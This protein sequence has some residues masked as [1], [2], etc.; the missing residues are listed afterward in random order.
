MGK[1]KI[2]LKKKVLSNETQTHG[3]N[4]DKELDQLS[5]PAGKL[6]PFIDKMSIIV[7]IPPGEHAYDMYSEFITSSDDPD[8]FA[9]AKKISGFAMGKRIVIQAADEKDYPNFQFDHH[10]KQA[11]RFRLEFS[12]EALGAAGLIELKML[13]GGMMEGGWEFVLEHGKITKLEVTVDI[14]KIEIETLLVL[15]QQ[16]TTAQTWSMGGTL[17]TLVL[18]KA[19]SNQTRIYNRGAKRKAKG[20]HSPEYEGTRVERILKTNQPL[21]GL[22]QMANPLAGLKII[23]SPLPPPKEHK[24]YIWSLFMDAVHRRSLPVALGLLPPEKRAMYREWMT[25]NSVA[26]WQPDEIWAQWPS[27]LSDSKLLSS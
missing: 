17:Q 3:E 21:S 6:R 22:H 12:P 9:S 23:V 16:R 15:P 13:L 10:A 2:P 18:G 7:P 14:P 11:K 4:L 24:P 26:W 8:V 1:I 25:M 20:Q 5:S 27:Y 19:N